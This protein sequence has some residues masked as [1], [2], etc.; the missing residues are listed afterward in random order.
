MTGFIR[1]RSPLHFGDL[2]RQPESLSSPL[3]DSVNLII[4][5]RAL[6]VLCSLGRV[7]LSQYEV[8]TIWI[9]G[10]IDQAADSQGN[11]GRDDD[12]HH[13]GHHERVVQQVLADD[14]G[15]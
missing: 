14:G 12:A 15:A 6:H 4:Q 11:K 10:S 2:F 7:T 3:S 9:I 1:Q 13:A 5:K 8:T